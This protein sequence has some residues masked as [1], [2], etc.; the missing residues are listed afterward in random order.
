M[1]GNSQ[2]AYKTLKAVIKTQ[3][4][5]S[6]VIEDSSGNILAESTAVLNRWTEYCNGLYNYE[7]HPDTSLLQSDQTP[8]REAESITVLIEEAEEAAR[9]LKAGMSPRVDNIPSE[10]LKNGG[11]ATTTVLT[12][13]RMKV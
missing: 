7:L 2:E 5:E 4:H 10:L 11:L 9:N 3:Q 6:A 8:T 13:I 1:S 12:A